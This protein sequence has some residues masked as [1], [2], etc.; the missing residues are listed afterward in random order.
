MTRAPFPSNPRLN[1]C[2]R[3]D[4]YHQ[5]RFRQLR[6]TL[7][8]LCSG[9]TIRLCGRRDRIRSQSDRFVTFPD[10]EGG[11]PSDSIFF[12]PT[13][14]WQK[15]SPGLTRRFLRIP[16]LQSNRR[17][18]PDTQLAFFLLRCRN[19]PI[20]TFFLAAAGGWTFHLGFFRKYFS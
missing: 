12:H 10:V 2:G 20:G 7:M 11:K 3:F 5:I 18:A 16:G 15:K 6:T 1:L 19:P 8:S 13:I 4:R 9:G 14:W 17:L